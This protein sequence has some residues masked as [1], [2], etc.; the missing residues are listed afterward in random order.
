M[1]KAS[2]PRGGELYPADGP[3][4]SAVAVLKGLCIEASEHGKL[5]STPIAYTP[6]K[7]FTAP[8]DRT[9]ALVELIHRC[10]ATHPLHS[11]A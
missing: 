10:H 2:K 8:A 9:C 6:L 5:A 7:F 4:Q 1:K 3:I 11:A